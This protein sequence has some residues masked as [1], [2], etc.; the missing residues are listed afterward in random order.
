MAALSAADKSRIATGL[1]RHW[2]AVWESMPLSKAQ[3]AA[4]IDAT[5]TWIDT[6]AA[7]Y[8]SALPTAARN[9][10]T[11]GQKTFVF[12]VVAAMRVSATWAKRL[13]GEVD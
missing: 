3:L 9:G 10:L 2:S 4:A 7:T 13:V 5:D 6:N 12:C 1:Q 11:A 8:N